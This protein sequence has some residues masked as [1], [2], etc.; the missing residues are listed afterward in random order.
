MPQKLSSNNEVP[1]H[2]NTFHEIEKDKIL[3]IFY[4]IT[5]ELL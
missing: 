3:L 5:Q 4:K 2:H 1:Y